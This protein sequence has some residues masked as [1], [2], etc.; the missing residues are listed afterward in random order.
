MLA[1]TYA[2]GWDFIIAV[3]PMLLVTAIVFDLLLVRMPRHR[4]KCVEL[5][6]Q[7]ETARVALENR[8]QLYKSL[9][10]ELAAKS[11]RWNSLELELRTTI[12]T[13]DLR[14][15]NLVS[16]SNSEVAM[17]KE[18]SLARIE[19][20]EESL[21]LEKE[22]FKNLQDFRDTRKRERVDRAAE[23]YQYIEK[24]CTN[25]SDAGIENIAEIENKLDAMRKAVDGICAL[26][27]SLPK[28]SG[29]LKSLESLA[30]LVDDRLS[31][32]VYLYDSPHGEAFSM[33]ASKTQIELE[34]DHSKPQ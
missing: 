19:E 7:L 14:I 3:G 27:E 22:K 1:I 28:L 13:Q 33:H 24:Y 31:N 4:R 32:L 30:P 12:G 18:T 2:S 20:L 9:S 8:D 34:L 26:Q 16:A 15:K 25:I 5:V 6:K 23:L 29:L 10:S 17:V 11:K 21:R